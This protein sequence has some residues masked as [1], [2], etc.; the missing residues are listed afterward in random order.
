MG[1]CH[2][3]GRTWKDVLLK[4]VRVYKNCEVTIYGNEIFGWKGTY[5]DKTIVSTSFIEDLYEDVRG[6]V[7]T[8][9]FVNRAVKIVRDNNDIA[10]IIL[11]LEWGEVIEFDVYYKDSERERF[12]G[13]HLKNYERVEVGYW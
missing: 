8:P 10:S 1:I 13:K 11:K 2:Y 3:T 5:D 6:K 12:E 4:R 7:G 9:E